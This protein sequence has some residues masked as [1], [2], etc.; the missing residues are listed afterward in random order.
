MGSRLWALGTV[1]GRGRDEGLAGV[2][3]Q[4]FVMAS[5]AAS[6]FEFP[7]PWAF[8]LI[9]IHEYLR[10]YL[11]DRGVQQLREDLA[12]RL[13]SLYKKT[14][15]RSWPWFEP[16]LTYANAAPAAGSPGGGPGHGTI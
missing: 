12:Q 9:G 11:G 8:A 16:T 1:L 4:L 6:Q 10:R 3:A 7:R 5:Q 14:S 15:S 13:L 2:A